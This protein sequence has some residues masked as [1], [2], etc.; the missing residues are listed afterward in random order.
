[1][2]FFKNLY[3]I[4]NDFRDRIKNNDLVSL[5]STKPFYEN[6]KTQKRIMKNNTILLKSK[7]DAPN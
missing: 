2:V 1:M 7:L 5:D 6:E 3:N 4:T